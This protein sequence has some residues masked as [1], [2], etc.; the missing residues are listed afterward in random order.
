MSTSFSVATTVQDTEVPPER[1]QRMMAR[2]RTMAAVSLENDFKGG[3]VARGKR[4]SVLMELQRSGG[5]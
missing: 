4:H 3:L 5:C 2:A 1:Y